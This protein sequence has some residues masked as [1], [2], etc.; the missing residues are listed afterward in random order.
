MGGGEKRCCEYTRLIVFSFSYWSIHFGCVP[1]YCIWSYVFTHLRRVDGFLCSLY[2][3]SYFSLSAT[4]WCIVPSP[5]FVLVHPEVFVGE[6]KSLHSYRYAY[7][8]LCSH[9]GG[10]AKAKVPTNKEK[11]SVVLSRSYVSF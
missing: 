3:F 11:E 2:W 9:T 10:R 8:P 7:T 4:R 5:I 1:I 6:K